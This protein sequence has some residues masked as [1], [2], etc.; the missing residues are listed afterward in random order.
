MDLNGIA[1]EDGRWSRERHG[2]WREVVGV[3]VKVEGENNG[4]KHTKEGV[5]EEWRRKLECL[6]KGAR[7]LKEKDVGKMSWRQCLET[8]FE[9]SW[10]RGGSVGGVAV[11]TT[12]VVEVVR[13]EGA[14][15]SL[16]CVMD[17]LMG[18]K[19]SGEWLSSDG[20]SVRTDMVDLDE[21]EQESEEV[22]ALDWLIKLMVL[23]VMRIAADCAGDLEEYREKREG[24][25]SRK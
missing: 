11:T 5:G 15:R 8:V 7:E 1:I 21:Q 20:G 2:L 12:G 24:E 16:S 23:A 10:M 3:P 13:T 4:E 6:M 19:Q 9:E 25:K 17:A 22:E 18:I 14:W